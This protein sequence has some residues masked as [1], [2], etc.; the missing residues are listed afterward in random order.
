MS[1]SSSSGVGSAG[2]S[3]SADQS[4][5]LANDNQ[6]ASETDVAK[7]YEVQYGDTIDSVAG[8]LNISPD[9]LHAVNP[10]V[11]NRDVLYPRD[12]LNLPGDAPPVLL[13]QNGP[14]TMT[15]ASPAVTPV[16]E[17][18]VTQFNASNAKEVAAL[19]AQLKE[20]SA[21]QSR[22]DSL[23]KQKLTGPS[24]ERV[25]KVA[26]D[27]IKERAAIH[28]ELKLRT[29]AASAIA[30]TTQPEGSIGKDPAVADALT[31]LSAHWKANS[32]T[33]KEVSGFN[34]TLDKVNRESKYDT[35]YYARTD[36]GSGPA[37][38]RR[39]TADT[40]YNVATSPGW[41]DLV[42]SGQVTLS[43]QKVIS[44]MAENEGGHM[45]SLQGW[46]SEIVTLGAMQK[47]VNAQGNG[48]LPK[49]VYD[50]SQTNPDK[51]KTLFADKGWT[52]A[53]T[54][55][56]TGPADYTMSFKDPADPKAKTLDGTALRNYIHANDPAA[57]DKTMTPL[58]AA[59]RDVDFQKKQIVDFKSRLN[60]AVDQVP[61]GAAYS[62]PISAYVTSEQSAALVLDQ[63]VNRPAHVAGS[64]GEALDK[65]YVANPKAPV[66]PATWTAEQRA[67]YES[68]I[69]ANYIAARNATTMTD[70]AERAAHI[71][72]AGSGL[73]AA[74]GS[75]VRTP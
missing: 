30:N 74:P 38:R 68:E 56:G 73:S 43:E 47:T 5:S 53:Q 39:E 23:G 7:T 41:N 24:G 31:S 61:T 26:A 22:I 13:A 52:V 4:Q 67:Q 70:P 20:L 50:F 19:N 58:L 57:W 64:F 72:D 62:K 59:G 6:D 11:L 46:D 3:S 54:G 37:Y 10:D 66:D 9:A 32:L 44:R 71:T 69:I 15:D 21:V 2:A 27:M 60:G 42:D 65:F 55:T 48:E 34:T 16:P 40:K 28:A 49:Q 8:S 63:S 36:Y 51:Y 35:P 14:T 45:D 75:F 25:A 18:A 33:D 1:I 17:K 29:E 12:Q